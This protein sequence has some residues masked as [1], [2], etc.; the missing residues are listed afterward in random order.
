MK[1]IMTLATAVVALAFFSTLSTEQASAQGYNN[2][3]QFGTGVNQSFR[4]GGFNGGFNGSRGVRR[5][6]FGGGF[7]AGF[8]QIGILDRAQAPPYFAQFP[9]VYYSGI[10]RRPYG[11]SPFAAPPGVEPVEFRHQVIEVEPVT[12]RN[13]YINNVE[14]ASGPAIEVE[15]D[16]A[17]DTDNKTTWTKNPHFDPNEQEAILAFFSKN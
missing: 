8:N 11:I 6:G 4:G 14:S 16:A 17:D 9:P 15:K 12:I 7:F 2:G 10:V 13:P 3:Y 1:N 5:G